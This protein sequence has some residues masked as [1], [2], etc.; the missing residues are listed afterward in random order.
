MTLSWTSVAPYAAA[1]G[2]TALVMLAVDLVWLGVIAKSLYAQAIGHLMSDE[3]YLPAALLFY[4][5]FP[6]GLMIFAVAP[7]GAPTGWRTA[8]LMGGLFGFFAYATYDLTNLT[9]LRNWPISLAL[10]DIAWGTFICGVSAAAGRA[11][12]DRMA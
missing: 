1:Y 2:V 5:I 3:P 4:A 12:L 9:T 6:L 8:L 11:T 7:V 10:I